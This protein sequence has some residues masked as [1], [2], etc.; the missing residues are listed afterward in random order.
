MFFISND[1]L[2]GK[3]ITSRRSRDAKGSVELNGKHTAMV[4]LHVL[5]SYDIAEPE[6]EP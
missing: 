1:E 2:S 3:A 4:R 5:H 6:P